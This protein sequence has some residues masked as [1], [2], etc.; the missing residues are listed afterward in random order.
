MNTTLRCFFSG[1][2]AIGRRFEPSGFLL[3]IDVIGVPFLEE[4]SEFLAEAAKQGFSQTEERR[5]KQPVTLSEAD[6]P[7]EIM[8]IIE[9]HI[10]R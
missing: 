1:W 3:R 4:P 7:I 9:L 5:C 10:Q 6:G 8:V 2:A